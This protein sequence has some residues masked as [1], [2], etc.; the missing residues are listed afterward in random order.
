MKKL[1]ILMV[2]LLPLFNCTTNDSGAS[3]VHIRLSN[4][5]TFNYQD[6]VVNT[7]TGNI[8]FEDIGSG[9][10]SDYKTFETAYRYAFVELKIDDETYTLQPTDY[11]GETPLSS[12]YYTYQIDAND[13][14]EQYHKLSLTLIKD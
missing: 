4:T 5:S 11:V 10:V 8:N 7:S 3:E 1:L 2:L 6:I 13:T 12:G 9:E 14:T